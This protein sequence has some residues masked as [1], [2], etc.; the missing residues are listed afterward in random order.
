MPGRSFEQEFPSLS[1]AP[2]ALYTLLTMQGSMEPELFL[3]AEGEN[4]KEAP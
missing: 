4:T 2:N 3:D 1:F